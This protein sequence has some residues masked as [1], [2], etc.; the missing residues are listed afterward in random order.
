[1]TEELATTDWIENQIALIQKT[2]LL[3]R[4]DFEEWFPYKGDNPLIY[5]G[6]S[7]KK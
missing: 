3:S 6:D 5:F 2:I 4:E 7:P 1:V